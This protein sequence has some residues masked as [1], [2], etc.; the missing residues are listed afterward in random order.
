M[1]HATGLM[2]DGLLLTSLPFLA[3]VVCN[4]AGGILGDQLTRRIG[5]RAAL[6]LIPAGCLAGT[7]LVLTAMALIHG[8]LAVVLLSS[9]GFGMMDLMLP[10]AWAMCVAIGGRF[11][12]TA[13]GV[14]NTAGQAGG[15]LAT[16]LFGYVVQASGSYNLPVCFIAV[17]VFI[18]ALLF[19]RV[20]CTQRLDAETGEP[21]AQPA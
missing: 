7:A 19:A 9:A 20:D 12:G 14:M 2:L 13:T 17:M 4:L 1:V 3:G 5:A 18:S 10:S 21:T 11:C 8:R 15:F 16:I 6:R